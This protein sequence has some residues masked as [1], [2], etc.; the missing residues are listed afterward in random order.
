M[1][2]ITFEQ[3]I[4]IA[5]KVYKIENCTYQIPLEIE[6]GKE[7]WKWEA[8]QIGYREGGKAGGKLIKAI[9]YL[10]YILENNGK[11]EKE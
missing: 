2:T 7:V 3:K 11:D 1:P 8:E 10:E 9:D 6:F 4:E 5:P